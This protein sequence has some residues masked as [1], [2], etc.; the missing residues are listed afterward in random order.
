[1]IDRT[2]V[3]EPVLRNSQS[4]SMDLFVQD[5]ELS[6]HK[7]YNS[8]SLAYEE[9]FR[10]DAQVDFYTLI[11]EGKLDLKKFLMIKGDVERAAFMNLFVNPRGNIRR[12]KA[13]LEKLLE[14]FDSFWSETIEDLVEGDGEKFD[15]A[16][17]YR[18]SKQ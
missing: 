9:V 3:A 5:L 11:R 12:G 4:E 7:P 10:L 14:E 18:F 6:L 15:D 17:Q 13:P 8:Q 1:M 16:I 2:G